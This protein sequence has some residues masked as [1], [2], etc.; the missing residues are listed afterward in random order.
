[1]PAYLKE[2]HPPLEGEPCRDYLSK[3]TKWGERPPAEAF[4]KIAN[5]LYLE[6][7]LKNEKKMAQKMKAKSTSFGRRHKSLGVPRKSNGE[8]QTE[9]AHHENEKATG[10]AQD[11]NDNIVQFFGKQANLVNLKMH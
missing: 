6:H 10:Q 9:N 11:R 7:C 8:V 1:M 4:M 5:Q 2:D 3:L